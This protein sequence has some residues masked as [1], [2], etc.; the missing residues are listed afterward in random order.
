MLIK[1]KKTLVPWLESMAEHQDISVEQLITSILKVYIYE[2]NKNDTSNF[3]LSDPP[4]YSRKQARRIFLRNI[5]NHPP[6][7]FV[8]HHID[9]NPLNN[10]PENLALVSPSAH[11]KLHRLL[12]N[13][14]M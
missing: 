14:K 4:R 6:K 13:T 9:G 3:I 10:K 8:I 12:N 1:I 2:Q 5:I 11:G 7:G